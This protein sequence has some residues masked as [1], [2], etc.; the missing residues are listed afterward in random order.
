MCSNQIISV[1]YERR[2]IDELIQILKIQGIRRL[3]DIREYPHSRKKG[4]SKTSLSET[5]KGAG[6]EYVHLREA[7]N[8]YFKQRDLTQCLA[9]YRA[10]LDDHLELVEQIASEIRGVTAVLCYER[11]HQDC[12]RSILISA[13][14]RAGCEFELI[15]VE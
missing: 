7:G 8:P 1:G 3:L 12:H 11:R 13:L 4:F 14:K 9:L 5:L 10:Y 15:E 6:I 2:S